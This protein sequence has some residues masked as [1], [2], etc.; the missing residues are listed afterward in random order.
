MKTLSV[1][2]FTAIALAMAVVCFAL[3]G[4]GSAQAQTKYRTPLA[5]HPPITA[6]MDHR[7]TPLVYE[8]NLRYDGTVILPG[9]S[10]YYGSSPRHRGTDFVAASGTNVYAAAGGIVKWTQTGCTVGD[11]TCGGGLGNW[12]AILHAD[13]W[14]SFYAHLS[15][16]G[17]SYN[18]SVSCGT[19]I[20]TSGNTGA[21]SGPHL[22]FEL[23]DG[24]SFSNTSRDPFAGGE[25]QSTEYWYWTVDI[26]DPFDGVG[27]VHYPMNVC[28]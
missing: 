17:V 16:V 13:G 28:Q 9:S 14:Y 11:S 2:R 7:H 25:S 20:G 23:R 15:T 26:T 4:G 10:F 19:V 21:S 18:Q 1:A 3:L 5:G 24:L 27:V 6:W 12:I 22:H 8:S